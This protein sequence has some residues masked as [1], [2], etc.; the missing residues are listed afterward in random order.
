MTKYITFAALAILASCGANEPAF[1]Q[2]VQGP[3]T[4]CIQQSP[5]LSAGQQYSCSF[6]ASGNLKVTVS[7]GGG[8]TVT[9]GPIAP[10]QSTTTESS[11]VFCA[12]A[13]TVYSLNV[14]SCPSGDWLLLFNATSAPSDGSVTPAGYWQLGSTGVAF[15]WVAPLKMTT[16]AV[17][18]C[19]STG[20]FTKTAVS[21]AAFTGQVQ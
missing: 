9:L 11:H 16:G 2:N 12:A 7:G 3:T 14:Q 1:A 18:V 5:A 19:S 8:G 21:G 17:T 4:Q 20:P 6:D 15:S 10:T 13:C